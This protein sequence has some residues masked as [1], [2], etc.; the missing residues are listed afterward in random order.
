MEVTDKVLDSLPENCTIEEKVMTVLRV[1]VDNKKAVYHVY[2]SSGKQ[3]YE[4]NFLRICEYVTRSYIGSR[5]Y[6]K[7]ISDEDR[8][9]VVSFLKSVMYGQMIDWFSHDM[10]YDIMAHSRKL[11]GMFAGTITAVCNKIRTSNELV[12]VPGYEAV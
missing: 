8:E 4:Q 6:S 5:E 7:Y 1:F 10:S 11:C 2:S 9:Y 3:F 12:A